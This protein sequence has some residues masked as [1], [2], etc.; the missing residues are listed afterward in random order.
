MFY[1]GESKW[2]TQRNFVDCFKV[3]AAIK[4]YL[5]KFE[6]FLFDTQDWNF[7]EAQNK[8]MGESV[9][10]ISAIALMKYAFSD[11]FKAIKRIFD[12]W[13]E[14][15]FLEEK[16]KVLICLIYI[17][18][19]QNIIPEKLEE[20]LEESHIE[21]GDIMPTLAQRWMDMGAK[22]VEDQ[23]KQERRVAEQEKRVAEQEKVKAV[24]EFVKR[25]VSIEIISAAMNIPV[26]E[27]ETLLPKGH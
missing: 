19:T 18:Q 4:E 11:D 1:H 8:E 6:Y 16:E 20:I 3:D 15:G 27:L 7:Q 10:L 13:Y 22:K 2:H 9:F 17:T 23:F 21:G 5:L 26:Q 25:G 14:K 24:K 12:F